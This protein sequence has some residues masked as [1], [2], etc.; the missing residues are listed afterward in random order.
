MLPYFYLY[1]QNVQL[2]CIRF[3]FKQI[4]QAA[5]MQKPIDLKV[6]SLHNNK[7]V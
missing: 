5:K 7:N 6:S 2:F 4:E 1:T 3:K